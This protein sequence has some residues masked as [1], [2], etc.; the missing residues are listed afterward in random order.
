[1]ATAVKEKEEVVD[2]SFTTLRSDKKLRTDLAA[3]ECEN[4][5]DKRAIDLILAQKQFTANQRIWMNT[6]LARKGGQFFET[7]N[8]KKGK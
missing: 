8:K 7:L 3:L 1:M 6:L 2:D 4:P 5:S